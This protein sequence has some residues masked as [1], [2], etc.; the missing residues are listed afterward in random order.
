V[1]LRTQFLRRCENIYALLSA[2]L[3][4]QYAKSHEHWTPIWSVT[5]VHDQ[6]ATRLG[7]VRQCLI[8]QLNKTARHLRYFTLH[9]WP[10]MIL[11][12][13]YDSTFISFCVQNAKFATRVIWTTLTTD[14]TDPYV[15][16]IGFIV[17]PIA[18]ALPWAFIQ[19][20]T[21]LLIYFIFNYIHSGVSNPF[22][23]QKYPCLFLI[24]NNYDFRGPWH[25]FHPIIK[26]YMYFLLLQI[27]ENIGICIR[28]LTLI[29][30][31][32]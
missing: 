13:L 22:F 25:F 29:I 19:L 9:R 7:V 3:L 11:I 28:K 26:N 6:R 12:L 2:Q 18:W 5:A 1:S 23:F 24:I 32:I 21:M 8:Y 16:I 20:E 31:I 14:V 17:R 4:D 15:I 10:A 27:Q 30:Q